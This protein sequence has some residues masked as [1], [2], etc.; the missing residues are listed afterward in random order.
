M[1]AGRSAEALGEAVAQEIEGGPGFVKGGRF[2]NAVEKDFIGVTLFEGEGEL[3]LDRLAEGAGAAERGEEVSSGL[4]AQRFQDVVAVTIAFVDCGRGGSGGFGDGAHGEGFFAAAGPQARGG[5]E[6]A[7][8]QIRVGM[9]GQISSR[10]TVF[11]T[12]TAY[13]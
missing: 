10:K 1:F 12:C 5:V 8:F 3:P 7:L 13:R 6:D 4:Q 2:G 9:T 11:I